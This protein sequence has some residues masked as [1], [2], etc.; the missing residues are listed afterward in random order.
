MQDKSPKHFDLAEE[1]SKGKD[2][3]A[4][5]EVRKAESDANERTKA[6]SVNSPDSQHVENKVWTSSS[7]Q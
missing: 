3:D 7:D 6:G 4:T 2:E 5:I 1:S